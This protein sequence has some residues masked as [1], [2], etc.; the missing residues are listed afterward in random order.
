M[1]NNGADHN[2]INLMKNG[3]VAVANVPP[4]VKQGFGAW[5]AKRRLLLGVGV[6]VIAGAAAA[7]LYWSLYGPEAAQKSERSIDQDD[8][9]ALLLQQGEYKKA[10]TMIVE[11]RADRT[12]SQD[13]FAEINKLVASSILAFMKERLQVKDSWKAKIFGIDTYYRMIDMNLWYLSAIKR[14]MTPDNGAF[15]AARP[16]V[17]GV[18]VAAA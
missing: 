11:Q 5:L 8:G 13:K 6:P 3:D 15:T 17:Q 1:N 7:Y 2:N 18:P 10:Y 14:T 4:V 9:A 12:W 16:P